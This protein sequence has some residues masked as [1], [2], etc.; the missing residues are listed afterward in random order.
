MKVEVKRPLVLQIDNKSSVNLARN[1]VFHGRSKHIKDKFH[2]PREKVNQGKLEVSHFS[3]E[4]QVA[5]FFTKGL[6]IDKFLILRK[7]LGIVQ[8]NYD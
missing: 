8:I 6:K 1:P 3:M 5:S 4:A 7:K 2:F